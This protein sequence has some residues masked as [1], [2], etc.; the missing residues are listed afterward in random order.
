[1][2][3][4]SASLP[5]VRAGTMNASASSPAGTMLFAPSRTQPPDACFAFVVT[6]LR[7]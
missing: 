3:C 1:M 2:P 7:R 6:W 4:A 5:A